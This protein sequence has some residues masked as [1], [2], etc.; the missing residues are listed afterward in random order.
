MMDPI[1]FADKQ[2]ELAAEFA[3]YVADHPE[4][5]ERLPA[6][7]HLCFHLEGETE[8]NRFSKDLA[9]NLRMQDQAP[10][11]LVSIK[12]LAPPASSRLIDPVIQ[13]A[14]ALR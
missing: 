7:S 11:V 13:P 12:G 4:V 6:K 14:S 3:Q 2:L 8:F 10:I 9:E 5:D 1:Q